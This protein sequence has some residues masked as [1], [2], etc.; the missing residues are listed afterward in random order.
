MIF[1]DSINPTYTASTPKRLL[2]HLR[3]LGARRTSWTKA[4]P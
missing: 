3:P 4:R 2:V 1:A